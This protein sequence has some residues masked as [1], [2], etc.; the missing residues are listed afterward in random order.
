MATALRPHP[1]AK[2]IIRRP[3]LRVELRRKEGSPATRMIR[4]RQECIRCIPQLVDSRP[5]LLRV[6]IL[7]SSIQVMANLLQDSNLDSSSLPMVTSLLRVKHRTANSLPM[8]NNHRLRR[9]T[10]SHRDTLSSPIWEDR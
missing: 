3:A 5:I 2:A 1:A 7:L 9:D 6:N 10:D 8:A 4:T